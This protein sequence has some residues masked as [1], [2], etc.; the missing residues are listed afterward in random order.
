M[1]HHSKIRAAIA[2][3]DRVARALVEKSERES[4]KRTNFH[5]V[6]ATGVL[7]GA[8]QQ[9]DYGEEQVALIALSYASGI[10]KTLGNEK[11]DVS[12]LLKK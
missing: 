9:L 1:M 5:A 4:D 3:A 7:D 12:W 8:R 6:V 2:D 11:L 10:I